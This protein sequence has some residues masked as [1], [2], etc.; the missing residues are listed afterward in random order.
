MVS[1]SSPLVFR[2]YGWSVLKTELSAHWIRIVSVGLLTVSAY[3]L[4]LAAYSMAPVSY[5][6]AIREVSVVLGAFA[7]WYFLNER[8]GGWRV[9]GSVIIFAGILVIAFFG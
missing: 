8:L 6:G 1:F 3:L 5:V 4:A 7:G 2:V 9:F